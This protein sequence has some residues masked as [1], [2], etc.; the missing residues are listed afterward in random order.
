[1][2]ENQQTPLTEEQISKALVQAKRAAITLTCLYSPPLLY[3]TWI[4]IGLSCMGFNDSD[5]SQW[6][7][8]IGLILYYCFLIPVPI[9][10]YKTW[11]RY[12][13]MRCKIN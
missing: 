10:I 3:I 1:M 6:D 8:I 5:Q 12:F 7:A 2:T 13:R 4:F 11:A 9:P